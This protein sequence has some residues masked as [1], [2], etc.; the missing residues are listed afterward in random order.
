MGDEYRIKVEERCGHSG[1]FNHSTTYDVK[2]QVSGTDADTVTRLAT[3][4]QSNM[5]PDFRNLS[6]FQAKGDD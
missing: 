2:I 3:A 4:V 1:V 6:S 5:S